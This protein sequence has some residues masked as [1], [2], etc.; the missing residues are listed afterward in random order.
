[1]SIKKPSKSIQ[2]K[3]VIVFLFSLL[4]LGFFGIKVFAT[5]FSL[6]NGLSQHLNN[7][8]SLNKDELVQIAKGLASISSFALL[9]LA[10]GVSIFIGLMF[11]LMYSINPSLKRLSYAVQQIQKGN[12]SFRLKIN[13]RNELKD[14]ADTLNTALDKVFSEEEELRKQKEHVEL[15]VIERTKELRAERSKFLLSIKSLPVGFMLVGADGR[16]NL[17]NP[18][19]GSFFNFKSPDFEEFKQNLE[20]VMNLISTLT[21]NVPKVIS[22]LEPLNITYTSEIGRHFK[23]SYSPLL[24]KDSVANSVVIVVEDVTDQVNLDHT[25]DEFMTI[26]SH[27]LRTPLASIRGNADLIRALYKSQLEDAQ[28]NKIVTGI[29]TSSARLSGIVNE[30]LEAANIEQIRILI[31][32]KNYN[33]LD[34]IT[35]ITTDMSKIAK[36]KG[37]YLKF[38]EASFEKA[39]IVYA[40]QRRVEQI[41][42]NLIG[43][44]FKFTEKGGVTLDCKLNNDALEILVQDT[45][46][47]IPDDKKVLLFKK[48]GQLDTD[49]LLRDQRPS[50]GLGLYISKH[51]AESMGGTI[52]LESSVAGEGSLFGF[53]LPLAGKNET[54]ISPNKVPEIAK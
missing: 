38:N 50:A 35:F 25:K 53:T 8:D 33:I 12:Y 43:N 46:I 11:D 42:L 10:I 14:I 26:A 20:I 1:M 45:G 39:P 32:P 22:S 9:Y 51:L 5:T 47:G 24:E 7:S 23:I 34:S 15:L 54:K 30:L 49:P 3:V 41:L 27:E 18:V 44:A 21:S 37:L 29:E 31:T 52:L 16:I 6:S 48:F 19:M 13:T 36:D 17:I 4:L 28:F 40:D 2:N